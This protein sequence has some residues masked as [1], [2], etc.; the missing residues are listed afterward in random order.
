MGQQWGDSNRW[1]NVPT[2][3]GIMPAKKRS[4]QRVERCIRELKSGRTVS[5][6]GRLLGVDRKTIRRWAADE[7]EL[8]AVLERRQ[9]RTTTATDDR[10][11]ELTRYDSEDGLTREQVAEFCRQ[12][13]KTGSVRKAALAAHVD[14][15]PNRI[16]P[17]DIPKAARDHLRAALEA[18]PREPSSTAQ[19]SPAQSREQQALSAWLRGDRWPDD[20]LDEGVLAKLSSR[21]ADD[22]R[23]TQQS[24]AHVLA[25]HR[26]AEQRSRVEPEDPSVF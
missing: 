4:V 8:A 20:P 24:R 16:R 1:D 19:S 10:G 17:A 6:T 26:A 14:L 25:R 22:Y 15:F 13:H 11:P 18:L 21:A 5:D 23:H 3:T 2:L 7:P 9:E 12:L